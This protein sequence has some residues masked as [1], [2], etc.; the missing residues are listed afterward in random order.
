MRLCG[1][2]IISTDTFGKVKICDFP[3]VFNIRTV[4]LYDN[5]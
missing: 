4:L 5:E 2:I 3:N 1:D